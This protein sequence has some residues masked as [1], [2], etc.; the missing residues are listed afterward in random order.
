MATK[1]FT[2]NE[3]KRKIALEKFIREQKKVMG[4]SKVFTGNEVPSVQVISSGLMNLD[5][6]TGIGG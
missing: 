4:D 5:V 2:E 3:D 6:A 1:E